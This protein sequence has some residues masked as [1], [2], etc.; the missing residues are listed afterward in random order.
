[1]KYPKLHSVIFGHDTPAGKAFDVGLILAIILSL[2]VIMLD[3]VTSIQEGHGFTLF[4]LEVFF[5][6]LFTVE[7]ILRLLCAKNPRKYARSFFGL[8]DL[9]AILPTYISLIFPSTRFLITIRVLRVLRVFRVLK[10]TQFVGQESVLG[11]ALWASRYKIS[12]FLL[13]VT[14]TVV[15]TGSLMYVIEGAENGFT[16]I[17]RS[18]YWAVVTLT[19]VGYGTITPQTPVGQILSA[20]LMIGG[21]GIVAVPTGIVTV[22]LGKLPSNVRK[23]CESCELIDHSPDASFCKKCGQALVST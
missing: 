3:S 7:Y 11:Q 23:R 16:S 2:I 13:S 21:Y 1:M 4:A 17:P 19:T 8:V 10:L 5:T 6:L 20:F 18:I 14:I 22:E 9:L 15:V 12:V